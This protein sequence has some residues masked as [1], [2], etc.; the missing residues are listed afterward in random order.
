M[1]FAL[2]AIGMLA[3]LWGFE[4]V[5][6]SWTDVQD[7]WGAPISVEVPLDDAFAGGVS[8]PGVAGVAL[9]VGVFAS[10]AG[11]VLLVAY[12]A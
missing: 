9:S 1:W 5:P 4:H 10:V 8:S 3:C 7:Q 2:V 12:G 11:V 6:R